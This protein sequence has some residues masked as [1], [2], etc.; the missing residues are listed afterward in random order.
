MFAKFI[1]PVLSA[2]FTD[3]TDPTVLN[4][5]CNVVHRLSGHPTLCEPHPY[6]APLYDATICCAGGVCFPSTSGACQSGETPYHCELG[7]VDSRG[8][9]HCY[10]EVP[11]YCDVNTCPP[12]SGGWADGVCCGNG[13]CIHHDL[14][15]DCE[16]GTLFWCDEGVT[17][18]DGTVTCLD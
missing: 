11:S 3:P 1:I 2:L 14:G 7:E 13:W 15:D 6:G 17:N 16:G 9:A 5:A 10:F 12:G 4:D 8:V 18:E